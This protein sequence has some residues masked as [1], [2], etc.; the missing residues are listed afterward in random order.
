M[1]SFR[2]FWFLRVTKKIHLFQ[3]LK[4]RN[5]HASSSS[6]EVQRLRHLNLSSIQLVDVYNS[7]YISLFSNALLT[8]SLWWRKF[9]VRIQ[10]IDFY[11]F[12]T[13]KAFI[14]LSW[15]RRFLNQQ[16]IEFS[17][18]TAPLQVFFRNLLCISITASPLTRKSLLPPS[19]YKK[20]IDA[21]V[22]ALS[23]FLA[24]FL[25]IV[26]AYLISTS[27]LF[28]TFQS[29]VHLLPWSGIQIRSF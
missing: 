25:L 8:F 29:M 16:A 19:S 11:S 9:I 27:S 5:H 12:F 3:W 1:I 24:L 4:K 26:S 20:E 10:P 7:S 17:V 6:H 14:F 21:V 2:Y 18:L 28:N 22:D 13:W 15:M 23:G